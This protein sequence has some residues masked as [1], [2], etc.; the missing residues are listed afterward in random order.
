MP[1]KACLFKKFPLLQYWRGFLLAILH[2][3]LFVN[4]LIPHPHPFLPN[5]LLELIRIVLQTT[6][7]INMLLPILLLP[8]LIGRSSL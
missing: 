2:V 6:I 1:S 4:V 8:L 3:E 7:G 5:S